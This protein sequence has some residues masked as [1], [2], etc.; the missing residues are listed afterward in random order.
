MAPNRGRH[1]LPRTGRA[2]NEPSRWY[3]ELKRRRVFR[4]TGIHAIVAWI[5]VQLPATTFPVIP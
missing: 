3:S 1:A 4:V 5:V 2:M